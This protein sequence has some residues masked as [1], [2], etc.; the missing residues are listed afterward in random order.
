MR[1]LSPAQAYHLRWLRD[2]LYAPL[3]PPGKH[4]SIKCRR[5][6][7]YENQITHDALLRRG[8]IRVDRRGYTWLTVK[9]KTVASVL[10]WTRTGEMEE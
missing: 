10:Y 6:N 1:L 2:V 4:S 9:G 8:L 5:G 3:D 7:H